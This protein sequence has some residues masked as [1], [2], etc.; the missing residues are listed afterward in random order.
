MTL[1]EIF[2]QLGDEDRVA[3]LLP[4]LGDAPWRARAIRAATA[5]GAGLGDYA[6]AAVEG[7]S[8]G[9]RDE[10]WVS[11][12]SALNRAADPGAACLRRMIDWLMERDGERTDP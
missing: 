3:R 7:F 12:L 9:A 2:G 11:L 8:A 5:Q 10:D 6:V 4:D 1:G